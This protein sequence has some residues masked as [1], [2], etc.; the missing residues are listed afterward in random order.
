MSDRV[1]TWFT[2]LG[3]AA[4]TAF[5]LVSYRDWP[6][7]WP[8]TIDGVNGATVLTGPLTGAIASALQLNANRVIAITAI[9]R[10]G[11]LV[12]MRSAWTASLTAATV[13]AASVLVTSAV[14]LV[15]PHGGPIEWW[16]LG[17][18]L[19][20]LTVCALGGS[21]AAFWVPQRLTV[22]AVPVAIFLLG[23]FAPGVVPEL[24][25]HGPSTGSL[26]GLK[27]ASDVLIGRVFA[28]VA[29]GGLLVVAMLPW[30]RTEGRWRRLMAGFVAVC[31]C[32]IALVRLDSVSSSRLVVSDERPSR[33]TGSAPAVCVSGSS[34]RLLKPT[35][36]AIREPAAHLAHAG[37]D[38]PPV[39]EELMP[40]RRG[41]GAHG[42]LEIGRTAQPGSRHGAGLL[43]TPAP[44][45]QWFDRSKPPAGVVF[46][47]QGL[48]VEWVV[49]QQ[50]EPIQPTSTEMRRWLTDVDSKAATAWVVATYAS[51][52]ACRFEQ[53]TMPWAG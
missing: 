33:C 21:V 2:A 43:M 29:V 26:A 46:E 8:W 13:F 39:F 10:R 9:T 48:L 4:V 22:V 49:A 14:T 32:A 16:A 42:M 5:A 52:R 24:L 53:I 30:R 45:P 1:G 28:L 18:G 36:E 19:L 50:G 51:L 34:I 3:L 40:S 41:D 15:G 38:L 6:G 37:V 11:W 31:L 23:T 7:Q 44:C 12:P 35:A 47:A 20:T 17:V 27:W 25:R